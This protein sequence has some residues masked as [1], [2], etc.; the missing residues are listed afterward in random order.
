M[1]CQSY[2]QFIAEIKCI[3][4][5]PVQSKETN[6]HLFSLKKGSSSVAQ[7]SLNF[8][9]AAAA[10]GWD[11][12]ALEGAF[13]HGLS[14]S[15]KDELAAPDECWHL[16]TLISLAFRLDNGL[17]ERRREKASTSHFSPVPPLPTKSDTQ[18]SKTQSPGYV[19]EPMHLCRLRLDP[20]QR[21]CRQQS[22]LCFYCG[23]SDHFG[24]QCSLLPKDVAHQ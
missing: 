9:I 8:R 24:S 4:D 13:F 6:Q 12:T 2:A 19:E 14:E 17:R 20:A 16:E 15:I 11:N 22:R 3:F 18:P 7:Y 23:D 10:G 5:H 1:V 21:P